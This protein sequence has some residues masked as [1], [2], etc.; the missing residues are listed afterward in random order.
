MPRPRTGE[1]MR[2]GYLAVVVLVVGCASSKPGAPAATP[3]GAAA[4]HPSATGPLR[5]TEATLPQYLDP[6]VSMPDL[7]AN[8][9]PM[10]IPAAIDDVWRAVRIAYD[11]LGI[12]LNVY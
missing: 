2:I 1:I 8:N 4:P 6:R 9:Q 5:S 12:P 3:Q 11:S 7:P 10:T